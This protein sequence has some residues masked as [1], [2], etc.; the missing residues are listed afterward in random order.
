VDPSG[1]AFVTG[2]TRSSDFPTTAGAF[3]TTLARSNIEDAFVSKLDPSGRSLAYS[4]YLGGGLEDFGLGIALD[5]G[6]AATVTGR[7]RAIDFPTTPDAFDPGLNEGD[8]A[9]SSD[10]FVTRLDSGGGA[11]EYSTFLG[12]PGDYCFERCGNDYATAAAADAAGRVYV[13]GSTYSHDFPTTAGAY[14]TTFNSITDHYSDVFVAGFGLAGTAP[15]R[16][17]GRCSPRSRWTR[18]A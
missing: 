7:T 2:E 10:A 18:R 15:R 1:A 4:T 12:A 11:L 6:G 9:R 8:S 17:P 5:D 13:A 14:D 16:R 3:D